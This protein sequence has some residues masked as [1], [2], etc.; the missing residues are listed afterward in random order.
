MGSSHMVFAQRCIFQLESI[1]IADSVFDVLSCR[2][3]SLDT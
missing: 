2:L 3:I 1:A